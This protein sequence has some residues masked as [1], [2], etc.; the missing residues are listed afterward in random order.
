MRGSGPSRRVPGLSQLGPV[1]TGNWGRLSGL[2]TSSR[3]HSLKECGLFYVRGKCP[4]ASPR[5]AVGQMCSHPT[6]WTVPGAAPASFPSSDNHDL[7]EII[8]KKILLCLK[9]TAG[10]SQTGAQGL[11]FYR[12]LHPK[13]AKPADKPKKAEE[14]GR[15]AGGRGCIGVPVATPVASWLCLSPG[16]DVCEPWIDLSAGEKEQLPPLTKQ[17]CQLG[18]EQSSWLFKKRF[19]YQIDVLDFFFPLERERERCFYCP[20]HLSPIP[21]WLSH[22]MEDGLCWAVPQQTLPCPTCACG[23]SA[24]LEQSVPVLLGEV[25]P[26]PPIPGREASSSWRTPCPALA[27][28]LKDHFKHFPFLV[29]M[30]PFQG[31]AKS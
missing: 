9:T 23:I 17:Y 28:S 20:P 3:I 27:L 24:Q 16:G 5:V 21:L 25:L 11:C 7:G 31:A 18:Q 8:Q 30:E 26:A 10:T 2:S 6:T 12:N 15:G 22:G 14:D 4:R 19:Q 1:P 29:P 13:C